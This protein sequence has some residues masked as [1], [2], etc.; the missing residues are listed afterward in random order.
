[1][2]LPNQVSLYHTSSKAK[3]ITMATQLKVILMANILV[4]L[5]SQ[6]KVIL[7]RV[8]QATFM[9]RYMRRG[10]R[11]TSRCRPQQRSWQRWRHCMP[12]R[13]Q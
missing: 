4:S 2:C 9:L 12:S 5:D 11:K 6:A 13:L 10:R 8:M 7:A 3:V 1:M